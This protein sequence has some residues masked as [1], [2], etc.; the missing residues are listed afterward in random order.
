MVPLIVFGQTQFNCSLLDVNSVI[1]DNLN[2]T[3]DIEIYDRNPGGMLYP[4]IAYTIDGYGDTIHT[5]N[6]NL[7]GTMGLDTNWYTYNTTNPIYPIYPLSIYLVHTNTNGQDTCIMFFHPSCDSVQTTFNNID[8]SLTPHI[9]NFDIQ[10]LGL[11]NGN[12]GYGG[13]VLIDQLGDT[14]AIENIS[15]A[16]NVFGPIS[17]DSDIRKLEILQNF[18]IPFNGAIH[19]VN[20]W[21]AGNPKTSCIFPFQISNTTVTINHMYNKNKVF[22][23]TDILGRETKRNINELLLYIYDDGTVEK[24]IIIE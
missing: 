9:I 5:G 12:F 17:Y 3:I 24:G 22:K 19:L 1:V 16:G 23:L 2:L 6:I 18:S 21:F 13:F 4:Y 20:G 8:S 7:F 10:T 15:T 11:S 14:I